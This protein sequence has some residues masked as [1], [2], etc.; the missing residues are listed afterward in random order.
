MR[1]LPQVWLKVAQHA[2]LG[3]MELRSVPHFIPV[4]STPE[5]GGAEAESVL[6]SP[7]GVLFERKIVE[8]RGSYDPGS[9]HRRGLGGSQLCPVARGGR[10][11]R[12]RAGSK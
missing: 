1:G 2:V 3:G 7:K 10:C 6:P 4:N 12:Q 11:F 8:C 9:R 5:Q